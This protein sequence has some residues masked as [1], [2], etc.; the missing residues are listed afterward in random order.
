M[1]TVKTKTATIPTRRQKAGC[2]ATR[3]ALSRNASNASAWRQNHQS[4]GPSRGAERPKQTGTRALGFRKRMVSVRLPHE[5][6]PGTDST[7]AETARAWVNERCAHCAAQD[8]PGRQAD[9]VTSAAS[10]KSWMCPT[11]IRRR[12]IVNERTS[13]EIEWQPGGDLVFSAAREQNAARK[14]ASME[15]NYD[16]RHS[17]PRSCPR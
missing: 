10:G 8:T 14:M 5:C 4:P 16:N 17:H 9:S 6:S 1:N 11:T 3:S 15:K 2:P 12:T 7:G 13:S